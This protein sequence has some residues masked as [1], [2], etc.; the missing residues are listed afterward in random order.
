MALK[1]LYAHS[2][3][4]RVWQQRRRYALH[5]AER[6]LSIYQRFNFHPLPCFVYKNEL[7]CEL[8]IDQHAKQRSGFYFRRIQFRRLRRILVIAVQR[9]APRRQSFSWRGGAIAESPAD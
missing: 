9:V 5:F 3:I 4:R 7:A 2:P 8:S 1:S 6:N